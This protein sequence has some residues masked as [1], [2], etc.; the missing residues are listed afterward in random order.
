MVK[1]SIPG[2]DFSVEEYKN[3]LRIY[4]KDLANFYGVTLIFDALCS[5]NAREAYKEMARDGELTIR[6]R[7]NYY[8]ES[9]LPK[10]QFKDMVMAKAK[11]EDDVEDLYKINTVKFFMEGSANGFY[12]GEP[13]EEAYLKAAG[14]P[15]G[16]RGFA[17]WEEEELEEV[18]TYLIENGFQIHTHAMGDQ[19]TTIT[20]DAYEKAAKNTGRDARNVIAHL[21]IVK[22]EDM[23][24]MGKLNIIGC[25]QPTWMFRE[26]IVDSYYIFQ[27]GEERRAQFYPYRRLTE[28]GVIVSVG[29]DFPVTP[30]PDP[31]VAMEGGITRSIPSCF[32][33][34]EQFKGMIAGPDRNPT[35]DCVDLTEA[36]K[37][38]TICG[39]Y[40]NFLE[41]ITGSIEVG[42]SAELVILDRDLETSNPADIHDTHVLMTIFKGKI[43]YEKKGAEL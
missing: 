34:Y 5:D 20:L 11:G 43:V 35:Q 23:K 1:R 8:A 2:C 15:D 16:Y 3:T 30:P 24:R 41:D 39:A 4:Q 29:T 27:F 37:G 6:V 36:I 14:L 42:K 13:F 17:F 25:V 33:G 40:Q 10:S 38:L 12:T 9:S 28:A 19:S 18:F 26:P 31:F 32:P 22:E 21:M 7:G